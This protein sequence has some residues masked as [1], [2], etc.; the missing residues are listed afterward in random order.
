MSHPPFTPDPTHRLEA[1]PAELLAV[2][3]DESEDLTIGVLLWLDVGG[4]TVRFTLCAVDG[5]RLRDELVRL[6]KP[7]KKSKRRRQP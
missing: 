4:G 7:P 2:E 6:L 5:R 3:D 1:F